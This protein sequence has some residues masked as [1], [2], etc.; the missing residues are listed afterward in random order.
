MGAELPEIGGQI[1][2]AQPCGD[3]GEVGRDRLFLLSGAVPLCHWRRIVM[4]GHNEV[5]VFRRWAQRAKAIQSIEMARSDDDG[6]RWIALTHGFQQPET[7]LNPASLISRKYSGCKAKRLPA[8]R[9]AHCL[10]LFLGPEA[11]AIEM[12]Q[13]RLA[14]RAVADVRQVASQ[15]L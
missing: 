8:A 9:Q 14:C 5:L 1:A 3:L 11:E 13:S 7:D 10:D 12:R 4:K 6:S 2:L 15:K